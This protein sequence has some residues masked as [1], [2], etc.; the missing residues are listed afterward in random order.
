MLGVPRLQG[1]NPSAGL[2]PPPKLSAF[3]LKCGKFERETSEKPLHGN[4]GGSGLQ[5]QLAEHPELP[6]GIPGRG[7]F[8]ALS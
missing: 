3:D 4:F 7:R 1:Q 8:R 6:L 5:P 2:N